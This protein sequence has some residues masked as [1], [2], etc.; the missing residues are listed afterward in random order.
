MIRVFNSMSP[1]FKGW[2]SLLEEDIMTMC[3]SS[4]EVVASQME[5]IEE[6]DLNA[7]P[8]YGISNLQIGKFYKQ[9]YP[10][11]LCLSIRNITKALCS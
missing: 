9:H 5:G 3:E 2:K 10:C 1:T 4:Q 8:L 6:S 11:F 7:I